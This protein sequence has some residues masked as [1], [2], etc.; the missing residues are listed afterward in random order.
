MKRIL[1]GEIMVLPVNK[2]TFDVFTGE[3]FD[4]HSRFQSFKGHLKLVAGAPVSEKE[5]N[6]LKE[7]VA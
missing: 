5:Y 2:W 4:N 3:G 7:L 6:K 1:K